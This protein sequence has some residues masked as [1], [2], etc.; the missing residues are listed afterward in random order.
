MP[1]VASKLNNPAGG[2]LDLLLGQAAR[3]LQSDPRKALVQARE[4]LKRA[5][6]HPHAVLLEAQALRRTGNP[7]AALGRLT[8]L[9]ARQPQ[10]LAAL[11]ELAQAASA[12][13]RNSQA[14]AALETLTQKQPAV[15]GG[16]FLLAKELRKAGRAKDAWRADL[17][18]VHASSRDPELL[19]AAVAMNEDKFDEGESVLSARLLRVPEDAPAIRLLG[20]INWRRGN[21]TRA[22][23][24]VE[25][26]VELA[27]GFDLARDFL[28]RL[29]MQNNRLT[30]ALEQAK[31]LSESPMKSPGHALL[32]ASV[33]VRLGEQSQAREI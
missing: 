12:A 27:P 31:I 29:L 11:W 18:G 15:P 21:M 6:G 25:S 23:E 26:A 28:I 19:K 13:G 3:L 9:V 14:I 10:M 2:P 24:L 20:E 16:W 32:K 22:L 17:S 7:Q 5:P 8:A 30:E 1:Q 4:A 33:L